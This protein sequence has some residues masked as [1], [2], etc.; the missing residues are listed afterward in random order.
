M[1]DFTVDP[2]IHSL[3]SVIQTF[4]ELYWSRSSGQGIPNGSYPRESRDPVPL[5][6]KA[7]W[8]AIALRR[9]PA[10][11]SSCW[12]SWEK[13][14]ARGLRR[15]ANWMFHSASKCKRPLT[16]SILY[17]WSR[18]YILISTH[19]CQN[20]PLGHCICG[21]VDFGKHRYYV[22]LVW[23]IL[24]TQWTWSRDG[25]STKRDMDEYSSFSTLWFRP[26]MLKVTKK[27]FHSSMWQVW[28]CLHLDKC[29]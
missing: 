4:A 17:N 5:P 26:V 15:W 1:V 29:Y 22:V 24:I 9:R 13:S 7:P 3:V 23:F 27:L 2:F 14:A 19:V 8:A 16:K 10:V 25:N 21:R 6:L 20:G 11:L 28:Y 18:L 12:R